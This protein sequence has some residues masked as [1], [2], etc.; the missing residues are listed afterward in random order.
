MFSAVLEAHQSQPCRYAC[1]RL[2][3]CTLFSCL[4]HSALF[5][6]YLARVYRSC[7]IYNSDCDA[8]PAFNMGPRYLLSSHHRY[9]ASSSY[10]GATTAIPTPPLS[11]MGMPR[12]GSCEPYTAKRTLQTRGIFTSSF[13]PLMSSEVTLVGECATIAPWVP[14]TIRLRRA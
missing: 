3:F 12:S 5:Y 9:L 6:I 4:L 2:F 7:S 10:R 14:A 11:L 13:L 1:P 8:Q